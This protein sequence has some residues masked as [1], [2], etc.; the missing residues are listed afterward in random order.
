MATRLSTGLVNA[1]MATG[2]FKSL[3]ENSGAGANAGFLIDVYTG[4]QPAAADDAASGTLLVTISAGGAGTG[5]T[6]EASAGSPN[7]GELEKNGSESWSGTAGNSGTAGWFRLRRKAD[8][9]TAS[10]TSEMRMDGAISTSGAQ[11][12]LGNLT[13]TAGAPFVLSAAAFTLPKA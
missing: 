10:S 3:F 8:A 2:S 4:T 7:A 5:C 12:N 13:V 1:L 9:G 11:M 6:F